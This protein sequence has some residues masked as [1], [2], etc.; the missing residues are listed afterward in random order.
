MKYYNQSYRRSKGKTF[1]EN[2]DLIARER[3]FVP[4][5]YGNGYRTLCTAHDDKSPSLS[6]AEGWDGKTLLY[7]H[8]GCP[9]KE[10]CGSVGIT[11]SDLFPPKEG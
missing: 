9:L 10:I 2:L 7:C 6:V 11:K 1:Q 3:N 8:A 4:Q 5:R